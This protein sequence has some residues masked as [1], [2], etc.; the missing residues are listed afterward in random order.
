M[1]NGNQPDEME[2]DLGIGGV[3][4]LDQDV[5]RVES[6]LKKAAQTINQTFDSSST[7]TSKFNENILKIEKNVSSLI[8]QYSRLGK[9]GAKGFEDIEKK[10][11]E[12][13]DQLQDIFLKLQ[14]LDAEAS[15]PG[16]SESVLTSLTSE[17]K[18]L[19]AELLILERRLISLRNLDVVTKA[20]YVAPPK[21]PREIDSQD[22]SK[23][24][25]DQEK[26]ALSLENQL[27]RLSRLDYKGTGDIKKDA[28]STL[29][30]LDDITIRLGTLKKTIA[31]TSDQNLLTE[32]KKDAKQLEGELDKVQGELNRVRRLEIQNPKPDNSSGVLSSIAKGLGLSNLATLGIAG[33]VASAYYGAKQLIDLTEVAIDRASKQINV[34]RLLASSATEAG[35]GVEFLSKK[36][37]EFSESV[38]LSDVK[39]AA[40]TAKIT[41]LTT[42]AQRPE[43]L[44]KLLKGFA[45][46]GAAR[47]IDSNDLETLVQQIITGQDEGYKKLLLPN[48]SQLQAEYAKKNNRSASSLTAVE[49][50]QILLDEITKKSE[51]FSGTA[52]ARMQSLD[53]RAAK[54]S[55]SLEN[56]KNSFSTSFAGSY[57]VSTLIDNATKALKSFNG[58]VDDL[59]DKVRRGINIDDL[60][61][62]NAKPGFFGGAA[63]GIG[64]ALAATP[65]YLG[66]G[67]GA[68]LGYGS[69]LGLVPGLG[70][71][72]REGANNLAQNANSY[73]VDDSDLR[74]N[75]L[76]QQINAQLLY[77][78]KLAKTAQER[79]VQIAAE[80]AEEEVK[81]I[82][83]VDEKKYKDIIQNPRST[84]ADYEGAIQS[85]KNESLGKLAKPL[86]ETKFKENVDKAFEKVDKTLYQ[87]LNDAQIKEKLGEGIRQEMQAALDV[88]NA[89]LYN[90]EESKKAIR[91][92]AE[93]LSQTLEKTYREVLTDPKIK[94]STLLS[95]INDIKGDSR[96]F[97]EVQEKLLRDA[98]KT[99]EELGKKFE[100]LRQ[101]FGNI[102]VESKSIDN[103]FVKFLYDVD[104]AYDDTYKKMIVFGEQ[105]AKQAATVAQSIAQH[106]LDVQTYESSDNALK[107][108]QEA[109]RLSQTSDTQTNGFQ[110]KLDTLQKTLEFIS[111]D[112]ALRKQAEEDRFYAS[113][114][115]PN[116]K[117]NSTDQFGDSGYLAYKLGYAGLD[118]LTRDF[119]ASDAGVKRQKDE[120][121]DDFNKRVKEAK[122]SFAETELKIRDYKE[123]REL[124]QAGQS[125]QLGIY[126]Q[127]AIAKAVLERLP[128]RAELLPRL[129]SYGQT[130]EDAQQLLQDRA[131]AQE[132]LVVANRRRFKDLIENQK[133]IDLNRTDAEE[134]VKNLYDK[135]GKLTDRES[136][137]KFLNITSELGTAELS[138]Q[139][140]QARIRALNEKAAI[141][142]KQRDDGAKNLLAIKNVMDSI[143]TQIEANG[144][145]V[146][147]GD[148]PAITINF[149][150]G[151]TAELNPPRPTANSGNN[152][153]K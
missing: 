107:L 134:R 34:N 45:D 83:A 64:S 52:E 65:Q 24:L 85:I 22:F 55:A 151:G 26:R 58:E 117:F 100:S 147:L 127:E 49:R 76:R 10:Q 95:S 131:A 4:E 71:N 138:P 27:T 98:E 40:T 142:E 92:Q 114:Y 32:L 132:V 153:G 122:N 14:K 81:R 79:R 150:G 69:P 38:G 23:S 41:Q 17:S 152:R 139:L 5:S 77:E 42:R 87:G 115:N 124:F 28:T 86:D 143:K 19:Q 144:L 93:K 89:P 7:Y 30:V 56:L 57:E 140:R 82:K 74:E 54:L 105:F 59:A 84:V 61:K 68:L 99:R 16:V 141:E 70:G 113:V 125:S 11:S 53:G 104:K 18:V 145:K 119:S 106:K 78:S 108:R 43:D 47:G 2:I 48:P 101:D 121:L 9:A 148:Q 73:F 102:L 29:K 31:S 94:V 110:R 1:A 90:E 129:K 128:T 149:P 118:R 67:L 80:N 39:G 60:I 63:T 35:L 112:R 103:P 75:F 37:K 25:L 20:N 130:K 136:L 15:K 116:S 62:K 88:T 126:G 137:D 33:G 44:D 8:G 96:L 133:F 135:G 66:A 72:I 91:E 109:R 51:L 46:L 36:N 13:L 3:E 146:D 6:I 111:T 21:P 97:P 12:S 120:S 50:T 123:D